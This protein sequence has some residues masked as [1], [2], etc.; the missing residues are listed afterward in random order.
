MAGSALLS[1]DPKPANLSVLHAQRGKRVV[2]AIFETDPPQGDVI[3]LLLEIAEIR[4]LMPGL[5]LGRQLSRDSFELLFLQLLEWPF[6]I[7]HE[8]IVIGLFNRGD[9]LSGNGS[10][11]LL[12]YISAQNSRATDE[13]SRGEPDRPNRC[14]IH[15]EKFCAERSRRVGS[16]AWF[17]RLLLL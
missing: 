12:R 15:G 2:A 13:H 16:A 14:D 6:S 7:C 17:G 1:P 5:K 8:R 11:F 3:A 9:E 4:N 10:V